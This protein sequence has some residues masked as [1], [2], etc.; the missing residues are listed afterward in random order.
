MSMGALLDLLKNNA[1][2]IAPGDVAGFQAACDAAKTSYNA[3]IDRLDTVEQTVS[4]QQ[5]AITSV[6]LSSLVG[7]DP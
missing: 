5:Q 3:E 6:R 4:V 7:L 1:A 2:N